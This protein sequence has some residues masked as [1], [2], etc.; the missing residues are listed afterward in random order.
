[1]SRKDEEPSQFPQGFLVFPCVVSRSSHSNPPP[2]ICPLYSLLFLSQA[3]GEAHMHPHEG[4]CGVLLLC[5]DAGF[6]AS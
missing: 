6:G 5:C 3:R 1:M 4:V 2:T